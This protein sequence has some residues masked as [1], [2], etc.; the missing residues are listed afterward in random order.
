MNPGVDAVSTTVA[1]VPDVPNPCRVHAAITRTGR[2]LFINVA[3]RLP[4]PD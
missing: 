1:V 3:A 4:V 2:N